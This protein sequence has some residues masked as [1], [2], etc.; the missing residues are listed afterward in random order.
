M[1]MIIPC[2]ACGSLTN[3]SVSPGISR[4]AHSEMKVR[5]C[6]SVIELAVVALS[7]LVSVRVVAVV[8]LSELVSVLVV[9][10]VVVVAVLLVKLVKLFDE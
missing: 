9:K 4:R 1:P 2:E 5:G 10:V 6:V 7:E 3:P 8:A